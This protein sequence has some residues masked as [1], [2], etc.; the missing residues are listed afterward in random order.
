[1]ALI[2]DLT[3]FL[4]DDEFAK[5]VTAGGVSGLGILDMPSEII[6]DGVVLTTDYKLTCEASKFG[7][8]AY[9]AGVNVD[10]HAYTVRNVALI[11][12]G[13]FCE[14]MLQRTATPSQAVGAPALLDG[15]GVA[16]DSTVIMDGGSP[17]TVYIEGNVL[18][19]GAP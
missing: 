16:S 17:D 13:A 12:D 3:V 5:P 6:A 11:D 18:D 4:S 8:L 10:G 7:D 1:M 14:V 9:G 19:A 2:E 15:D